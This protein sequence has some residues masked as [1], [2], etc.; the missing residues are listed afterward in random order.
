[1]NRFE[2]LIAQGRLL[3]VAKVYPKYVKNKLRV[4]QPSVVLKTSLIA[5]A[6]YSLYRYFWNYLDCIR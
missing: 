5:G 6:V 2:E 1:M 3:F 4:F